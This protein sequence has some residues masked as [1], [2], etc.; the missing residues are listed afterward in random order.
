MKND[1]H[2]EGGLYADRHKETDPETCGQESRKQLKLW[3]SLALGNHFYMKTLKVHVE[4]SHFVVRFSSENFES[5][6]VSG[7]SC[8]R[9]NIMP[10]GEIVINRYKPFENLPFPLF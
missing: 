10:Q 9:V 4:S 7:F 1:N 2:I 3:F 8:L 5:W 6:K